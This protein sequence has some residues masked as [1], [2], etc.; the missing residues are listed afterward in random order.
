MSNFRENLLDRIIHIYGFEDGITIE[1][2]TYLETWA[3]DDYN[4]KLLQAIV[5]YYEIS[6]A[7]RR[8]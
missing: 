7:K 2:A 5:E 8:N 1:I 4:D 3:E 6:N